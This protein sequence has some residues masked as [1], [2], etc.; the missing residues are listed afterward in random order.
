[1]AGVAGVVA[2]DGFDFQLAESTVAGCMLLMLLDD[3][4]CETVVCLLSF[5]SSRGSVLVELLAF[6]LDK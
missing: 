2:N 1:M 4:L 3:L 5:V 6:L